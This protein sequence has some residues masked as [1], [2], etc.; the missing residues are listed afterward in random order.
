M[1]NAK[2]W[3]VSV[4]LAVPGL[5]AVSSAVAQEAPFPNKP[6]HI[7]VP[8]AAGSSADDNSRFYAEL[9]QRALKVPVVVENKPGGAGEIGASYVKAQPAD[10]YTLLMGTN[11]TM[12]LN[13]V[14]KKNLSYDAFA[15]FRPVHGLQL[16]GAILVVSSEGPVKT[17]ADLLS[18]AK[19]EKRSLNIGNYSDGYKLMGDWWAH[20]AKAEINHVPYKGANQMLP[21]LVS[22]RLDAAFIDAAGVQQMINAGKLRGLAITDGKRDAKF[23]DIPTMKESGYAD[24]ETYVW[25]SFY[26]P[27]KTPDAV[28]QKLAD[29]L[30]D[31]LKT[32]ES[33]ARTAARPGREMSLH[34]T[35]LGDFQ[36]ADAER[37]KKVLKATGL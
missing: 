34:T 16:T 20:E 8:F 6:I 18:M 2:Q 33:K 7:V 11:S 19:A 36:R 30:R 22:R 31:A 12:A 1:M 14:M 27:A 26:V 9:M 3:L 21:D 23:P 17:V 28:T 29:T 4:A 25:T 32:P 37:Y 24:F 13:P 35:A 15:D 5:W 10:G